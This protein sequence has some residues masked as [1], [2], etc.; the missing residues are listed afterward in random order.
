MSAPHTPITFAEK[1]YALSKVIHIRKYSDTTAL[2]NKLVGHQ[3]S[4]SHLRL[5]DDIALLLVTEGDSEVAAVSLERTETEV[6][7]YY[8]KNQLVTAREESYIKDLLEILKLPH[9]DL[10]EEGKGPD[11]GGGARVERLLA[12]VVPACAT[13]IKSRI[14]KLKHD[15][16]GDRSD[17]FRDDINGEMHAY[18]QERFDTWYNR[19]NGA[20]EFLTK[21]LHQIDNL[22]LSKTSTG[23][24][25]DIIRVAYRAS[26]YKKNTTVLVPEH[27][28]RRL[29]LVGDYFGAA[30]RIVKRM[31]SLRS[32]AGPG[33]PLPAIIFEE[34]GILTDTLRLHLT[35]LDRFVHQ[36]SPD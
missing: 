34:V 8:A 23:Q 17:I 35:K 2:S 32:A 33:G 7:F 30:R 1:V 29:R 28:A 15:L 18:F 13:K 25:C 20:H 21:F 3:E 10:A 11:T 4:L 12:K 16:P 5:L 9:D 27:L 6:R 36:R 31:D 22:E 24:L 19:Y 14:R 26:A